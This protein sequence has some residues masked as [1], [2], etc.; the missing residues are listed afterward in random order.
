MSIVA[1]LALL[2]QGSAPSVTAAVDRARLRMGEEL[3]LTVQARTRSAEALALTLPPLTGFA[4]VGSS[5]RTEVSISGAAGPLR[6]TSRQLVLRAMRAGTVT[7]GPVRV[8]QGRE[9]IATHPITIVI[10]SAT[11]GAEAGLSPLA[12]ALLVAAQAPRRIDQVALTVLVPAETVLV[13]QQLDIVVAAW[14]PRDLRTRLRRAPLVTL[15]TPA[16]VWAYPQAGSGDVVATRLVRGQWMDLFAVHQVVFPL[17]PGRVMIPPASVEYALPVTFSF[18]SREDRYT[19]QSDSAAITVLPLPAAGRPPDDAAVVG[20]AFTVDLAVEPADTR[21]S[22]PIEVAA[23]LRGIGNVALWP[24]PTLRW[25][26]GFRAYPAQTTTLL[27][28]RD[29]LVAGT[30][31]F[32]YLVVPDSAGS[33]LLPEVRYPYYDLAAGGYTVIRAPPRA[34]VIAPGAEP[35]AARAL[36]PLRRDTV[37]ERA[38][39]VAG[40]VSPLGWLALALVPPAVVAWR[41]RRRAPAPPPPDAAPQLSR[42]GRLEREFHTVLRNHVPDM[43]AREGDALARALRAAGVESAVAD[44]VMRLRDRLRAAR[45]GPRGVGDPAELAAELEQVLQVL[46]AES[47]GRRRRRLTVAGVLL[48]CAL[49]PAAQAGAGERGEGRAAAAPAIAAHWYNLGAT[50]YRAGADGKATAAWTLAARLAPRDRV[51]RRAREL[52]PVPDAASEPLLAVGPA[53]PGECWLL[54]AALWVTAWVLAL[55]R[56]RRLVVGG[57]GAL[58]LAAVLLGATEWRRR[59]RPVAVVV[60]ASPVRVAPYGAASAASTVD[61]GAALLVEDR[62][63]RW[64]EVRRADGVHGWL[65]ATEVVRL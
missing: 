23:S 1:L 21:V 37:V 17:G 5:E 31:T 10:D 38:D 51:I 2:L 36:P 39:Q 47:P 20:R 46:G 9:V 19:L 13:G 7:I 57:L 33:F 40:S 62:Y 44:H 49:A 34:L 48:A 12:H 29:G 55:L 15:P 30:K 63:G 53:T 8:R 50:L 3:T 16:G 27:E 56:G 41:R 58:A 6:T 64:L 65:L 54:A 35:R 22:E 45:Y 43:S 61:A 28:P 24:E 52:L 14:F 32:R 60:A 4:I 11:A 59:A 26:A 18:F 25:P 42:L